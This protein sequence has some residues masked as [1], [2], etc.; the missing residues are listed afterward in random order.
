MA[1][2]NHAVFPVEQQ[3]LPALG[4][5]DGNFPLD[6]VN[7]FPGL[8]E[9]LALQHREHVEQRHRLQHAQG[10]QGH[11]VAGDVLPGQHPIEGAV[12]V[13]H[14][15]GGDVLLLL[16]HLPG[17]ALGD[18]AAEDGR[19][20][21]IQVPHLS[22]H[23]GNALGGLEAKPIQHNLSFVGDVTQAGGLI[24]PI[25]QRVAQGGVGHGGDDGIRIGVAVAGHI[26]RIH[27][28][29]PLFRQI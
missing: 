11:I 14:G 17:P 2:E 27:R 4:Q 18:R 25:A 19:G 20:I 15:Q 16:Q 29:A 5:G 6:G 26:N 12:L 9:D 8:V 28:N 21:E 3:V 7:V 10:N 22:V 24:L 23:I 13:G 1:A